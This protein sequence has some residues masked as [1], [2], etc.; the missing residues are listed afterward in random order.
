MISTPQRCKA[1]ARCFKILVYSR[2]KESFSFSLSSLRF[3]SGRKATI[4]HKLCTMRFSWA[5][6]HLPP[7][8]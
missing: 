7:Q 6:E 3:S 5:A 4:T 8:Q 2:M 1:V